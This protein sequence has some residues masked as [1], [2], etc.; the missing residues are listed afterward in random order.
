MTLEDLLL[1]LRR[2]RDI[3]VSEREIWW[4]SRGP[5]RRIMQAL[6]RHKRGIAAMLK[7]SDRWVCP[8]PAHQPFY[9]YRDGRWLCSKCE[10]LQPWVA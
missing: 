3:L 1:E 4:S 8:T 2:R 7:W 9:Y 5:D 6:K 10:E